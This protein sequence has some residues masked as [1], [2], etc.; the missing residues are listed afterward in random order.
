MHQVENGNDAL[1][2]VLLVVASEPRVVLADD[3]LDTV[4][5]DHHT[6]T[7]PRLL[8]ELLVSLHHLTL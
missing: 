2:G 4:W 8:D 6:S 3:S 5:T 7:P 1:L